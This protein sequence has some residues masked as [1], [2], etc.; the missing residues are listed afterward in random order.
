MEAPSLPRPQTPRQLVVFALVAAVALY[1]AW[2]L[3]LGVLAALTWVLTVALVIII[4]YLAAS[5]LGRIG[6]G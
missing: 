4:L 2:H 6:K 1:I 5:M 3:F